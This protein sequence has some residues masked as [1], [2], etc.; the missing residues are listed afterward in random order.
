MAKDLFHNT[1]KIALSKDGWIIISDRLKSFALVLNHRLIEFPLLS[2]V[3]QRTDA[4]VAVL[5]TTDRVG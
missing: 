3:H 1:V 2:R 5:P 4:L